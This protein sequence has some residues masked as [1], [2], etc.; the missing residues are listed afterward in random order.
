MSQASEAPLRALPQDDHLIEGDHDGGDGFKAEIMEQGVLGIYDQRRYSEKGQGG[1]SAKRAHTSVERL[2]RPRSQSGNEYSD[3]FEDEEE[4]GEAREGREGS[5]DEE[6]QRQRL[7]D[8]TCPSRPMRHNH[9]PRAALRAFWKA[10]GGEAADDEEKESYGQDF[11]VACPCGVTC[12]DGQQMVEC[13]RCQVHSVKNYL[14]QSCLVRVGGSQGQK[15]GGMDSSGNLLPNSG[16]ACFNAAA[17]AGAAGAGA[18]GLQNPFDPNCGSGGSSAAVAAIPRGGSG[19]GGGGLPNPL[20]PNYD[21]SSIHMPNMLGGILTPPV[22]SG[23]SNASMGAGTSMGPGAF[24]TSMGAGT[25]MGPGA[26]NTSMGARTSMGPGA[27][28]TSM[29]AGT[30]MDTGA[31]NTSMA[32]GTSMCPGPSTNAS[33]LDQTKELSHLLLGFANSE[34]PSP[35]G[36]KK[37]HSPTGGVSRRGVKAD[38]EPDG[39][40]GRSGAGPQRGRG[41]RQSAGRGSARYAGA[42]ADDPLNLFMSAGGSNSRGHQERDR[43][44]QNLLQ[45]QRQP[46]DNRSMSPVSAGLAAAVRMRADVHR[47]QAQTLTAPRPLHHPEAQRHASQRSLSQLAAAAIGERE[48]PGIGGAASA[49]LDDHKSPAVMSL[50]NSMPSAASP[51]SLHDSLLHH[52][53]DRDRDG[54]TPSLLGGRAGPPP[55]P[56]RAASAAPTAAELACMFHDSDDEG[57]GGGSSLGANLLE[58]LR[59]DALLMGL[60]G[61]SRAGTPA[62][63]VFLDNFLGGTPDLQIGGGIMSPTAA[64]ATQILGLP[65]LGSGA[66]AG[67]RQS[68][69]AEK[70]KVHLNHFKDDPPHHSSGAMPWKL[71]SNNVYAPLMQGILS[72][73]PDPH[74]AHASNHPNHPGMSLGLSCG[75][76]D[77]GRLEGSNTLEPTNSA[78]LRDMS[79]LGTSHSGALNMSYLG[80][81]HSGPLNMLECL[82]SGTPDPW[83]QLLRAS[84]PGFTQ[85]L[86]GLHAGLYGLK[87]PYDLLGPT[88]SWMMSKTPPLPNLD[89][90]APPQLLSPRRRKQALLNSSAQNHDGGQDGEGGAQDGAEAHQLIHSPRLT[91]AM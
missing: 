60:L 59:A 41:S 19:G 86:L 5:E 58:G 28:N 69:L 76:D 1:G 79:Y 45:P 52:T 24:N 42:E 21:F 68:S 64:A 89:M 38:K 36:S 49:G 67:A 47:P 44:L 22:G 4:E 29:G 74:G 26:F 6:A 53:F 75:K 83:A 91:A 63:H 77:A 71:P 16:L 78:S 61:G 72:S 50:L 80:T 57:V 73:S 12:D 18:D 7:H 48:Y 37:V 20:D 33:D 90:G 62:S 85:E 84:T 82:R 40:S 10:A 43:E 25:S 9:G 87:S 46:P 23:P 30:S 39:V 32:A 2:R 51:R 54:Y 35:R 17:A 3:E 11:V 81:A 15:P 8:S 13:E 27:F 88:T 31:F 65:P 66:M 34:G 56:P 55:P 14:C 70:E